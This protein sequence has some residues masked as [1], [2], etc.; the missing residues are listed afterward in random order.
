M[1]TA[2]TIPPITVQQYEY[3]E[4]FP[5]LRDELIQGRILISRQPKPLHQQIARN[6]ERLLETALGA[7]SGYLVRQ[8][9]NLRFAAAHS[10]PSPDVFVLRREHWVAACTANDY[11]SVAPF[12]VVEVL[13]PANRERVVRDK[14]RLYLEEGV[15]E[16]WI[17]SP[18]KRLLRVHSLASPDGV[19]AHGTLRLPDPLIGRINIDAVFRLDS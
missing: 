11:V 7:D 18:K 5:G 15:M 14:I 6:L 12:L 4:G 13:S 17:V 3:F 16:V 8:N 9:S 19:D 2:P 10:M 1:A